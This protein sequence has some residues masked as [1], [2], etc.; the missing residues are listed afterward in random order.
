M[1][2]SI[3]IMV[4]LISVPQIHLLLDE[5]LSG[6]REVGAILNPEQELHAL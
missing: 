4:S 3:K 5:F 2:I 1:Y 6:V